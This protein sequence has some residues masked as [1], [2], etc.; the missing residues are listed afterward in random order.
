MTTRE[1]ASTF[2]KGYASCLLRRHEVPAAILLP[3]LFGVLG[4]E[5]PF[6]APADGVHAV[7]ADPQR[8]QI[9]LRCLR[10]PFT[11]ADVVFGGTPLV[12]MAFDGYAHL[13]IGTQKFRRLGESVARV[14]A[15]IGLVEIKVSVLH[16]LLEKFA[17]AL[18]VGRR[19]SSS[20]SIHGD[21]RRG[22]GG[23][24]RSASGNGVSRR[25]GGIHRRRTLHGD[26]ANAWLDV[27]VGGVGRAPGES[28]RIAAINLRRRR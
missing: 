17:H 2:S 22:R 14:R 15:Y 8:N 3:A 10:A 21:A 6:F 20:R 23:P 25:A 4:A 11:Q 13:R 5:G 12:A 28:R 24:A 19:N 26:L 27:R 18:I 16:V 7:R 9:I 1:P